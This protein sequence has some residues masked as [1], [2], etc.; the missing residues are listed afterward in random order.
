MRFLRTIL[1]PI[2]LLYGIILFIRNKF[3]DWRIFSSHEFDVPVIVVGNLATGGTGKTPHIEYLIRLLKEKC[4]VATLSRGYGRNS[5]GFVAATPTSTA[6][7]VGDEP[8]QFKNK[9]PDISVAVDNKR[10]RGIKKLM[11]REPHPDV[12]LLD[13]AFQHRPVVAG[14]SILLTEYDHLFYNDTILPTGNLREFRS[15]YERADMIV[16]TKTP[17]ILPPLQKK[18]IIKE[19]NIHAHQKIYFSYIKYGELVPLYRG[20][21]TTIS[22]EHCF[23]KEYTLFLMTGIAN[24]ASLEEY[25]RSKLKNVIRLNFSDH[26]KY[27]MTELMHVKE[28][29]DEIPDKNKIILTTEKD[30]MRLESPGYVELLKEL[31]VYYLPIEIDFHDKDKEDF[32]RQ[33]LDYVKGNSIKQMSEKFSKS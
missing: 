33:I 30:A 5:S 7:V 16:I 8:R 4:K 28:R 9:F 27:S 22:K 20:M 14:V 13:D 25:L 18:R 31:P 21:N 32:D 26:H 23:E 10:V 6:A 11:E 29:F 24:A 1:Y 2:S 17:E 3:Y 15:G 19:I 12:I